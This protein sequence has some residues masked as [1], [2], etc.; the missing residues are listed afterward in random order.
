M[1]SI[2]EHDL[3][4]GTEIEARLP[5]H[6]WRGRTARLR[7]ADLSPHGWLEADDVRGVQHRDELAFDDF[8]AEA[9]DARWSS[10]FGPA[11]VP[12]RTVV[13]QLGLACVQ[14]RGSALSLGRAGT[15]ALVSRPFRV[16]HGILAGL[17]FDC[18][19]ADTRVELRVDGAVVR[20]MS[21]RNSRAL[22]GLLFDLEEF[23][24]REAVL[25]VIDDDPR[26]GFGIG[27]D[28]LVLYDE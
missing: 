23:R 25:A 9:Y 5:V 12:W 15:Q 21:G 17:V 18:G 22:R 11:P 13:E 2:D 24:G 26:P 10:T 14:G 16:E 4:P 8:E 27:V 20:S 19:G 1:L 28:A 6:A 7:F 3:A